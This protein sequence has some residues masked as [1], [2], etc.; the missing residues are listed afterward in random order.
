MKKKIVAYLLCMAM[1]ASLMPMPVTQAA[2]H[3][4]VVYEEPT[5]EE[6]DSYVQVEGLKAF[7]DCGNGTNTPNEIVDGDKST[8]W[9]SAWEGERQPEKQEAYTE[10][11]KNN[12]IILKL[13]QMSAVKKIVYLSNGENSNGT[14][15]K[16]NLYIKKKQ[17]NTEK[18]EQVGNEPYRLEFNQNGAAEIDFETAFENVAEIK[19]EVLNT[20][21][22]PS[23]TFISGKELSVFQDEEQTEAIKIM[24]NAEC[25]S[26]KDQGIAKLVD[27]KEE[28]VYH[29][30]WGDDSGPTLEDGEE[31]EGKKI[32]EIIRPE[33]TTKPSELI[34]KNKIYI[35]LP[36]EENVARL[37]YTSRQ[38]EKDGNNDGVSNGRITGVNIYVSKEEKLTYSEVE[39]WTKASEETVRWADREEEQIFDFKPEQEGVRWICLEVKHSAGSDKF[40]NAAE[41]AVEVKKTELQ[42]AL[43]ELQNL[44][45]DENYKNAYDNPFDYTKESWREF[46]DAYN[47]AE[48]ILKKENLSEQDIPD[49]RSAKTNLITAKDN[50]IG[51]VE[52]PTLNLAKPEVGKK[53]PKAA[54]ENT[55][56]TD[57]SKIMDIETVWKDSDL[58]DVTNETIQDYKDYTAEI[59]L[60]IKD[61]AKKIFKSA[62]VDLKIGG[63]SESITG[64]LYDNQKT[65]KLNYSFSQGENDHK[66]AEKDL[67]EIKNQISTISEKDKDGHY[68]Y[69]PSQWKSFSEAKKT[70]EN[71]NSANTDTD[72]IKVAVNN[73]KKAKDELDE[74]ELTFVEKK[75][76]DCSSKANGKEAY[77]ECCCEKKEYYYYDEE[78]K[79]LCLIEE[80]IEDWGVINYDDNHEYNYSKLDYQWAY[81]TDDIV[82]SDENVDIQWNPIDKDTEWT[83][84]FA[85]K[86]TAVRCI[87]EVK[88]TKCGE[89]KEKE[90]IIT[91]KAV[92]IQQ[93]TCTAKG[94][95]TYE[96]TLGDYSKD[97]NGENETSTI[98]IPIQMIEHNLVKT[99]EIAATCEKDGN[100]AYYTCKNEN[101]GKYFSDAEGKH[102]IEKD[103][104]VRKATG[105]QIVEE[106]KKQP[107]KKAEG[108]LVRHCKNCDYVKETL[109]L[110]KK[111]ITIYVGAKAKEVPK[112]ASTYNTSDYRI[113]YA[114][115]KNVKTY[116][117]YFNL[118]NANKTG[119]LKVT[120][121]ANSKKLSQVKLKTVPLKVTVAG[122]EYK[123]NVK[124]K[125]KAPK[126][127]ISKESV[128]FGGIKGTRYHLKYNVKGATRVKIRVRKASSLDKKFDRDMSKPKSDASKCYITVRESDLKR[129]GN[130]LTFEIVAYYGKNI[131]EKYVKT[132]K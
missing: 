99:E 131:S 16:C 121:K 117:K 59:T 45:N 115:A 93:P 26:Q 47:K 36:K 74:H 81:T 50:L 38:K 64:T 90:K 1:G 105:H 72:T 48:A 44:L 101:C 3:D 80:S 39:N 112:V 122:K 13:A 83:L 63:V 11:I 62:D 15:S 103:S 52:K 2:D 18:F 73:L 71:I 129:Y 30:T 84:D 89:K 32:T 34:K 98:K 24:A 95:Y 57:F 9:H 102:E 21:G 109:A 25:S 27:G 76:A 92:E 87:I 6:Q 54:F 46:Q 88:C 20:N 53:F 37:V 49:I 106:V 86:V 78:A 43:E 65:L 19:I 79:G 40:I 29:S 55:E 5:T 113:A 127:T 111:E 108:Q 118:K 100:D 31:F 116:G 23:N 35:L 8:Y 12:N 41:I 68:K 125:I 128:E 91:K 70:V 104:W 4:A 17:D 132:V 66:N 42:K 97:E 114:K 120:I 7:A 126:I 94:S 61:E 33:T 58:N 130:K 14:I 85:Q 123:T 56:N 107:T 22:D 69:A 110:P 28:T 60:K 10:M 124:V 75:D 77:Y 119:N 96:V 82:A 67:V 51:I